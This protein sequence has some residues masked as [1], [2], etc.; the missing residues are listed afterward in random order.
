[1]PVKT[2]YQIKGDAMDRDCGMHGKE[3]KYID[4]FDRGNLKEADHL[5]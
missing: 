3:E 4:G 1:L 2:G 5:E